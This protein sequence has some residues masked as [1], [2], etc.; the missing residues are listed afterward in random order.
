MRYLC[1]G[2]IGL[3]LFAT[4]PGCDSGNPVETTMPTV[5]PKAPPE[6]DQIKKD[7]E[8]RFPGSTGTKSPA[9]QTAK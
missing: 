4:A 8:K 3:I 6:A 5:A 1:P 2:V 9:G 7:M